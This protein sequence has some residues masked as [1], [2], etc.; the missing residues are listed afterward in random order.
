M[1]DRSLPAQGGATPIIGQSACPSHQPSNLVAGISAG[2]Q[3]A[4]AYV[5]LDLDKAFLSRL[6]SSSFRLRLIW[7]AVQ[8][9][10]DSVVPFRRVEKSPLALTGDDM[11]DN[12]G[13]EPGMTEHRNPRDHEIEAPTVKEGDE[14]IEKQSSNHGSN[15]ENVRS[16][17]KE[18][19]KKEEEMWGKLGLDMGTVMMMFKYVWPIYIEEF[20]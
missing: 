3:L 5:H 10:Q 19:K 1:R 8:P 2:H 13:V 17:E 20:G 14:K 9:I 16:G 11:A 15:A 4:F 18:E 6:I 12:A 7:Q